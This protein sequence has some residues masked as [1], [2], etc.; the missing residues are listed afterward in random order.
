M[1]QVSGPVAICNA[2]LIKL[3]G[4]TIASFDEKSTEAT[5]CAAL[6]DIERRSQ[7]RLHPWKFAIRRSG[8]GG[9]ARVN[10]TDPANEEY[11]YAYTLPS[12]CIKLLKVITPDYF[13]LEGRSILTD[14][15]ECHI[16]YVADIED[17]A[18]WDPS[19]V[20]VMVSRM[21]LELAYTLP[22]KT[23]M[24][25]TMNALYQE[26]LTLARRYNSQEDI[27]DQVDQATPSLIA[28]RFHGG[29]G[30]SR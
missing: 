10:T 20:D 4:N 29:R 11:R 16:K 27:E 23:S 6:W 7:L 24:I 1:S 26:R 14:E 17:T 15:E 21:A 19:F 18:T 12:D 25:E 22:A 5:A 30:G 2:A 13:K 3:R 28:S 9:L 8:V